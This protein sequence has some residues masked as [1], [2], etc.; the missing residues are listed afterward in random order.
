VIALI[1]AW[2]SGQVLADS[3][4]A[5]RAQTLP[6]DRI[7]VIAN[8]CTDNTAEVAR[9]A[10]AE[11]MELPVCRGRKAGALNVAL[12]ALLPPLGPEDFIVVQ[13]DD[14]RLG[15]DWIANALRRLTSV[16]RPAHA[17]GA[18][19]HGR[20]GGGL[21]GALQRN[22][23]IRFAQRISRQ[24]GNIDVLSGTATMFRVPALRAVNAGRTAGTLPGHGYV[25]NESSLTEDH[26]LT[27]SLH[28]LGYRTTAPAGCLV[29]TD[30]MPTLPALW[31]Q[32]IRWQRGTLEDLFA[33]GWNRITVKAFARQGLLCATAFF[34]L[35]YTTYVI[36]Q[37]HL[38]SWMGI[39]PVRH[40]WWL[41]AGGF[42]AVERAVT[43][44]SAGLKA[45][46]L[47]AC[48]VPEYLFDLFRQVVFLAALAKAAR[49]AA[50]QWVTT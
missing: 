50:P 6:P 21:I 19:F 49:R 33:F 1:P 22:E 29:V 40:P 8:N 26:D 45:M 44:R 32:R 4:A 41:A 5:L 16:R 37:V 11:V 38:F 9:V 48:L 35:V 10:G 7:I 31:H 12:R 43:V 42:L 30:I 34:T 28:R 47:A 17:V 2:N 20:S 36:L 39:S 14:T 3:V 25:Y 13:D 27:L 23:Y 24:K 15:P 46:A 18:T